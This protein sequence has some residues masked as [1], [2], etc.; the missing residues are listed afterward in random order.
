MTLQELRTELIAKY[1]QPVKE[2]WY[3]NQNQDTEQ[4]GLTHGF[5]AFKQTNGNVI[6]FKKINITVEDYQGANESAYFTNRDELAEQP[7]PPTPFNQRVKN[8]IDAAVTN[9][10]IVA[11]LVEKIDAE[12]QSAQVIGYRDDGA[13]GVT[14]QTYLVYDNNG[15]LELKPLSNA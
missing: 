3:D 1:G 7:T 2:G 10:N 13:G 4:T 15:T 8:R 6:N 5:I 12:N 14:S 11:G 9:N